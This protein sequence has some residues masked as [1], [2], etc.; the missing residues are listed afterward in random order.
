MLQ[1]PLI[2]AVDDEQNILKL[3]S[4][5]LA[6]EGYRIITAPDG[7][8]ALALLDEYNPD[9]VIL[10]IMMPGI[11]GIEVVKRIRQKSSVP[12]IMLTGKDDINSLNQA[13]ER[14]ADD[15]ITKPFNIHV[16]MARVRAKIRR[17]TS[18]KTPA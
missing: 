4:I 3:I 16:L 7:L 6:L 17:A 1:R 9:L 14:G 10:D 2:M 18:T 15:Y 8:S 5:N 11:D 13:L 12:I